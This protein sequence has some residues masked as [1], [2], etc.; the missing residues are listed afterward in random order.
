[1]VP[2]SR[3]TSADR[4]TTPSRSTARPRPR[5]NTRSAG[6]PRPAARLFVRSGSPSAGRRSLSRRSA[7]LHASSARTSGGQGLRPRPVGDRRTTLQIPQRSSGPIGDL[8]DSVGHD[9]GCSRPSGARRARTTAGSLSTGK[10]D[11]GDR[12]GRHRLAQLA[13]A[14]AE[15]AQ[16]VGHH[17]RERGLE[18]QVALV[19]IDRQHDDL[20]L[21]GGAVEHGVE[22]VARGRL[23]Q[24]VG[25]ALECQLPG[26]GH[27]HV[28]EPDVG[29]QRRVLVLLGHDRV[30]QGLT[31]LPQRCPIAPGR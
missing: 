27:H 26:L 28:V 11:L 31:E 10:T 30:V 20:P 18:R 2:I 14:A 25:R 15:P 29:H 17:D 4:G 13:L 3:S 21:A 8:R 19:E 5:D 1:M 22:R 23:G 7:R 9:Q 16:E 24:D 12:P 6:R